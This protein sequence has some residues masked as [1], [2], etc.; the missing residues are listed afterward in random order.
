[1][2]PIFPLPPGHCVAVGAV[3]KEE[4]VFNSCIDLDGAVNLRKLPGQGDFFFFEPAYRQV[5]EVLKIVVETYCKTVGIVG[6]NEDFVVLTL[7]PEPV[8]DAC[9]VFCGF[10]CDPK[11]EAGRELTG[12]AFC[13]LLNCSDLRIFRVLLF[14]KEDGGYNQCCHYQRKF[15]DVFHF[16]YSCII[17]NKCSNFSLSL[18][19]DKPS[20]Y[21]ISTDSSIQKPA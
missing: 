12:D 16:G 5:A 20:I 4:A 14:L 10:F 11:V 17:F 6:G 19:G 1:M 13:K 7:K 2:L 15:E 8:L 18:Q 9:S 3:I 21:G